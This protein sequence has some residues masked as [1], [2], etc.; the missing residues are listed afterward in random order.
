MAPSSDRRRGKEQTL[1]ISTMSGSSS[2]EDD[3][4][5]DELPS[6]RVRLVRFFYLAYQAVERELGSM[7][8]D[9]PP[10]ITGGGRFCRDLALDANALVR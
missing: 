4:E 8:V 1:D 3:P 7:N 9:E 2:S 10:S 5:Y 6:R